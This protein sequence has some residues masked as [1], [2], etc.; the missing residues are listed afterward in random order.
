MFL[1]LHLVQ[2]IF[3]NFIIR[4]EEIDKSFKLCI[5]LRYVSLFVRIISGVFGLCNP[6]L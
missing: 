4:Y 2:E 1:L 3:G 5:E 6:V